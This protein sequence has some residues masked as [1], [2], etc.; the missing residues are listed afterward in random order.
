MSNNS[1][2]FQAWY[3]KN[4]EL[5]DKLPNGIYF[6]EFLAP[7]T[8]QYK[9]EYANKFFL[10]DV[11]VGD[12]F[13]GGFVD[14]KRALGIITPARGAMLS[15]PLLYCGK[16]TK[17]LIEELINSKSDYSISG[18][19]EGVVIKNY[20]LQSFAKVKHQRFKSNKSLA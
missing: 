17:N 13:D 11:F 14:Y 15:A 19:R 7:H 8:I 3:W 6:G 16:V 9:P 10:I 5:F 12:A 20:P 2:Y 1:Q 18:K 4:C